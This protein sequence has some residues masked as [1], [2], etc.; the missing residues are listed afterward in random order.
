MTH[1]PLAMCATRPRIRVLITCTA[2]KRTILAAAEDLYLGQQHVRLMRGVRAARAAGA[3]VEV[4]ILSALHGLVAGA[5]PLLPYERQL[6]DLDAEARG[7]W[8]AAA[9]PATHAFL[10]G[11]CDLAL[12]LLSRAYARGLA[13]DRTIA[14]A[15]ARGV[16]TLW[17]VAP[18]ERATGPG[19][20]RL[21]Q[22]DAGVAQT[23][24]FGAGLTALKGEIAGRVLER[25]VVW[26]SLLC[27]V[28]ACYRLACDPAP[29]S[30]PPRATR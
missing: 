29:L 15:A 23:R 14:A 2:R 5:T 28:E 4:G 25:E 7:D 30:A 3:D 10:T 27:D 17:I 12:V 26:R 6:A 18:S 8:N 9:R 16:P 11:P 13:L 1:L 24:T 21:A 20:E 19:A 22:L